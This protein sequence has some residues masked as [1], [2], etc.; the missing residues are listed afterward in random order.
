MRNTFLKAIPVLLVHLLFAAPLLAQ[1]LDN[2]PKRELRG[3]WVATVNN[4]DFP[5]RGTPNGIAQKEQ[6]KKL[7]ERLKKTG[8]NAVFVQIRPA[9]DALYNS[10]IAPWSA[11]LTGKQGQAPVPYYDPL[12]FMIDFTHRCGMEFHAWMN[13]YRATFNMDTTALAPQHV[14]N[15]HRDWVLRYGNRFYLDPGIPEVRR[16]L[17]AVVLE[18]VNKY[19]VDGIHFDDYFYPY[20]IQGQDFPDSTSFAE[21]GQ[22][23]G[24]VEDWRRNNVDE[25]IQTLYQSIKVTKSHVAFGISPFGVW[26]NRSDDPMGSNTRAGQRSYDDLYADVLKWLKNGWI[27]YVVPQLYW[28]IGF[29]AADHNEL[30][31]WWRAHSYEK[32]LYIGY[33][34]YKVGD[35]PDPAWQEPTQIPDQLRLNRGA[36]DV[37]GGVFFSTKSVLNNPLGMAD[38]LARYFFRYPALI[39]M[40]QEEGIPRPSPPK[41][42]RIKGKQEGVLLRWKTDKSTT[43]PFLP[44]DY[45]VIYRFDG[46]LVGNMN[47]P[48]NILA[49]TALTGE[50]NRYMDRTAIEENIY[51]YAITAVNRQ[52]M[53]SVLSE[54]RTIR[55]KL[56][57]IKRLKNR[58]L[59][60]VIEEMQAEQTKEKEQENDN[61][62]F[63]NF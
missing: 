54:S 48:R 46:P 42:R 5:K 18:V 21:Y 62:G 7:I 6:W 20:R 41:L 58:R 39:P 51:T 9:A 45:Q 61:D 55:K 1:P 35:N 44:P 19:D 53:E 15:E 60:K 33:A 47:D 50:Q 3:A 16:H 52:H 37:R 10:E 26:R 38:S 36:E 43:N 22:A 17:E 12:E 13:P 31:D 8:F 59:R 14:F 2:P 30:F 24:S 40:L 25:L 27:D 56:G 23:F 34:A 63:F 32:N 29:P 4:I 11:Y 28:H 49:I 57:G